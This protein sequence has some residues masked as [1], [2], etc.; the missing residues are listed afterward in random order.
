MSKKD[1]DFQKNQNPNPFSGKKLEITGFKDLF[2]NK[3]KKKKFQIKLVDTNQN[4]SKKKKNNTNKNSNKKKSNTNKSKAKSNV[5]GK[6]KNKS[7]AK[8]KVKTKG[9]VKAKPKSNVKSKN[10]VKNKSSVKMKPKPVKPN[11]PRNRPPPVPTNQQ[12]SDNNNYS[13]QTPTNST[14][15][16]D[17]YSNNDT[18]NYNDTYNQ[19]DN[20][21][22]EP[23]PKPKPKAKKVVKRKSKKNNDTNIDETHN[24]KPRNSLKISKKRSQPKRNDN[25]SSKKATKVSKKVVKKAKKKTKKY[26][27]NSDSNNSDNDDEKSPKSDKKLTKQEKEFRARIMQDIISDTVDVSFK[28]VYGLESVKLAIYETII[29]PKLRPELFVGLIKPSSGILLFGPPGNGKTMIAKCIASEYGQEYTFFNI[30]ASSLTSKWVGDA[31]RMMRTL[32]DIAREKSPSIIFIDEIDSILTARGGKSEAESSRRIK[33]EF[34]IQFDGVSKKSMNDKKIL[35]IGATNLPDQLDN[36]VLRRFNKRICVPLPDKD[37]RINLI[38]NLLKKQKYDI[39]SDNMNNIGTKT[40]G[41]SC[42]DLKHLCSDA[43]MGPIRDLG[44]NILNMSNDFIPTILYKHFMI[45]IDNVKPSLSNDLQNYY[46]DWNNKY[47]SK[48]YLSIDSLPDNMKPYIH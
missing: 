9:T 33:T 36:A 22:N 24:I 34:L 29:L 39:S 45:S 46:N 19:N 31:E 2:S 17:G 20:N 40:D 1:K 48:T 42:S 21:I 44:A 14:P 23:K 41:Y 5:N 7:K 43:S 8:P 37:T 35:I 38:K 4:K 47:G 26:D 12:I 13:I 32:F 15:I 11:I 30:S 6:S 28:D 25:R 3:K 18:L 16:N 10:G 27:S